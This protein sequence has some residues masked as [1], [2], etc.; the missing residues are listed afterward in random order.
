[1]EIDFNEAA[2]MLGHVVSVNGVSHLELAMLEGTF[3]VGPSE[4]NLALFDYDLPRVQGLYT[5]NGVVGFDVLR[6]PSQP[7]L[8]IIA[9]YSVCF[10]RDHFLDMAQDA[11]A[12]R[13][14]VLI[15]DIQK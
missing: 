11:D 8:G 7:G 10:T 5:S 4:G 13:G 9:S 14:Y 2:Q 6:V 15:R 1:M 3:L 12:D